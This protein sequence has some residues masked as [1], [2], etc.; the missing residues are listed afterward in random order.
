MRTAAA[1]AVH[2]GREYLRWAVR[3]TAHVVDEIHVFYT[4]EPSYGFATDLTCPDTEEEL[5]QAAV[6]GV[7]HLGCPLFWHRTHGHASEHAMRGVMQAHVAGRSDVYVVVDADE[8]WMP[9]TLA[10]VIEHVWDA[11]RAGR[12]Q[13]RFVNF[14]RS[15]RWTVDDQ[16]M[17]VRIVDT[18]HPLDVDAQLDSATQRL[19]VFHFGYAQR[20]ELMRYKMAIHGHKAEFRPGWFEEKFLPWR[21]G[22]GL[23]DTHPAVNNLWTPRRRDPLLGMAMKWVVGDHPYAQHELIE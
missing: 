16:F 19:P 8:V 7:R 10:E 18:R 6:D 4:R 2:Y 9:A 17:P 5:H 11:N 20:V 13:A 15:F 1:F 23:E 14:W 21:P 3:S 12:W 22:C